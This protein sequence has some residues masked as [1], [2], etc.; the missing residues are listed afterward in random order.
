MSDDIAGLLDF[1]R[2]KKAIIVGHSLGGY[3]ALAFARKYPQ[4]LKGLGLVASRTNADNAAQKEARH[5]MIADIQAKGM[6]PVADTMAARLVVDPLPV[7]GLRKLILKMD[8]AGAVGAL[9]AMAGRDD[10]SNVVVN[11]KIP[12]MVV[13][14]AADVLIPIETSRQM[15]NLSTTST[16]I[17]FEGVGHMPMLEAPIKTAEAINKLI[18]EGNVFEIS[19]G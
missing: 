4:K 16:Y 9:I 10:F 6:Q 7:A 11:L 15:A 18:R 13:A 14:G 5:R 19:G 2:I 3:V 12:I 17:E 8:P 1:L